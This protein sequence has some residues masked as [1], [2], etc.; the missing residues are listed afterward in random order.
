MKNTL[1]GFLI[2]MCLFGA[3][4][5]AQQVSDVEVKQYAK[6]KYPELFLPKD[7]FETNAE[8]NQR[9]KRQREV[10]GGIRKK[11]IDEMDA[12]KDKK[13][14]VGE[15]GFYIREN[16]SD[17]AVMLDREQTPVLQTMDKDKVLIQY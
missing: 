17:M 11:L 15:L 8:Y 6:Q 9:L 2:I 10:L 4:L 13:I 3:E 14:T 12:N 16:V 5:C 1:N 7:E